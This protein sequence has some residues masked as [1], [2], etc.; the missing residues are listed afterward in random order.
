MAF[1]IGKQVSYWLDTARDDWRVAQKLLADNELRQGM[2]L[3]HL[4]L[5]KVL[6]AHVCKATNDYAPRIH[7]LAR[8]AELAA[9]GLTQEQ[10][11]VLVDINEYNLEGRYPDIDLPFIPPNEAHVNFQRA[12]EMYEWLTKQL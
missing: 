11:D 7:K 12:K 3:V 8:L 5:E 2:F 9:L 6:K 1:D 10:L 4:A